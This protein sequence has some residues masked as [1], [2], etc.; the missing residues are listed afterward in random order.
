MLGSVLGGVTARWLAI[1][2][3]IYATLGLA[4]FALSLLPRLGSEH[5][6][7]AEASA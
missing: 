1:D 6:L 7:A 3:L 5:V 4:I 2:G